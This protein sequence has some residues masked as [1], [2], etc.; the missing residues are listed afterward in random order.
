MSPNTPPMSPRA[1]AGRTPKKNVLASA[2]R[3]LYGVC[4]EFVFGGGGWLVWATLLLVSFAGVGVYFSYGLIR[5]IALRAAIR[6]VALLASLRI[7]QMLFRRW[8]GRRELNLTPAGGTFACLFVATGVSAFNAGLNLLYV[9][10]G[11]MGGF[12]IVAAVLPWLTLR[13]VSIRRTVPSLVTEG[14]R[15]EVTLRVRHAR[16]WLPSYA[17]RVEDSM[18]S[19]A[20]EAVH[21]V[22]LLRVPCG[23]DAEAKYA[24]ATVSRGRCRFERVVLST[25]FPF[26]LARSV[27]RVDLADEI[28]SLP[29]PGKAKPSWRETLGGLGVRQP[30]L[31]GGA[32]G[33]EEFHGLREYR[34]G[35]NPKLIH[36]RT[37]A[38]MGD[39]YVREMEGKS[40]RRVVMVLDSYGEDGQEESVR[41]RFEHA[42]R[43]LATAEN[44]S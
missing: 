2:A 34:D 8:L 26:G 17:V 43:L 18:R 42:I 6:G 13:K 33:A 11:F 44:N 5:A 29:A 9:L 32:L 40:G 16:R 28:V 19:E 3:S 7:A 4:R 10:F 37:S 21:S 39:L 35:D 20:G 12:L 36:W 22:V 1:A 25:A 30:D 14:Q 31:R 15:F 38:R 24:M 41:S 23:E 27:L